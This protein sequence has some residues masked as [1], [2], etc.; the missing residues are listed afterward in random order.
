M[1]LLSPNYP[2][3]HILLFLMAIYFLAILL[4]GIYITK[5]QT[6]LVRIVWVLFII[7]FPVVGI[8]L[9]ILIE[10]LKSNTTVL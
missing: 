4:I 3:T 9:F 8:I 6:N 1:E 7:F 5:G 2:A 10:K